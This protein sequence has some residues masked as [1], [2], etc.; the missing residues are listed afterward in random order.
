MKIPKEF[1]RND[2]DI[3]NQI[4]VEVIESTAK[5]TLK[6]GKLFE[7]LSQMNV[8]DLLDRYNSPDKNILTKV[9][10]RGLSKDV[11]LLGV[12]NDGLAYW[13][14]APSWDCG[15]YWGFGYVETF[16]QNW[17]PSASR[18][19]NGHEHID[20]SFLGQETISKW[21]DIGKQYIENKG[22]YIH[23][24]YDS[25]KFKYTTFSEKEG[26][27]LSELFK[28]FYL[29]GESAGLFGSGSAHTSSNPVEDVLKDE[30]LT[31]RINEVMIPAVTAEII[32]IL[33][34]KK[35]D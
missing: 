18:D 30:T 14:E 4:I 7:D 12:D 28:S 35:Q 9:Y 10:T 32:K 27:T 31:K 1:I 24:I 15:W 17:N 34:P 22:K 8:P 23:N 19:I 6:D 2:T 16:T 21:D 20:T 29:L 3:K 33:S 26:W 11:Y 5:D 25:S 13:L